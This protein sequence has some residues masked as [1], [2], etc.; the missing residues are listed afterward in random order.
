MFRMGIYL[1]C[2]MAYALSSNITTLL[3]D[4][5]YIFQ[6]LSFFHTQSHDDAHNPKK[7]IIVLY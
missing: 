2:L 1:H 3:H 6:T 7:F 5:H 4:E